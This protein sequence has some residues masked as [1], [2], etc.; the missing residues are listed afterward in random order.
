M[1]REA[2]VTEYLS[3]AAL[4]L[5]AQDYKEADQ[6]LTVYTKAKG[7]MTVLAKGV[8][9]NSSKL[10][11][12]LQLFGQTALTLTI[13]K[14]IP[15]VINAESMDI[16]PAIRADLTRISYAGYCAEL[17]DRLLV[18]DEY[19][20]AVFRLIL[21]SMNLLSYI[22]P[23][24]AAKTLEIRLLDILGYAPNLEYCQEC[25]QLLRPGEKRL[26]TIGGVVCLDCGQGRP[27]G[28]T[29]PLEAEAV[30]LYQALRQLSLT[31]LGHIYASQTARRQLEA[32]LDQQ[33]DAVVDQPLKTRQFLRSM[34]NV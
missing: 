1:R 18:S 26:G 22:D 30:T 15:V 27:P 17:L 31:Q 21:Q 2:D 9:K 4:V 12:G 5:R 3:T 20:D 8:K 11:G 25:G 7:K 10:R 13:G 33:I 16:F 6:L 19:D 23:W 14:G 34:A 24:I 32:Y 29:M 28:Q